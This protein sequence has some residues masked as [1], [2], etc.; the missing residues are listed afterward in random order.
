M[1]WPP[2]SPDLNPIE[3]VWAIIKYKTEKRLPKNLAEVERIMEEEWN[4]IPAEL[5]VK[6]AE[7]MKERC[8]KV[9]AANGGHI[10]L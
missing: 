7:S 5:L 2:C 10:D 9:I 8:E 6:L 1:E 4:S 3:N